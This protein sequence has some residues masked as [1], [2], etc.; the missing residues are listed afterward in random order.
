MFAAT[1]EVVLLKT[2]TS[3]FTKTGITTGN[4]RAKIADSDDRFKDL[5][6]SLDDFNL[7]HLVTV[8]EDRFAGN[9]VN[10]HNDISAAARVFTKICILQHFQTQHQQSQRQ[11][12][13][14]DLVTK[15]Q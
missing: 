6:G 5:Q 13:Q 1:F 4:R 14:R 12:Y 2:V 3:C 9:V 8:P 7:A 11:Q 15:K 10:V